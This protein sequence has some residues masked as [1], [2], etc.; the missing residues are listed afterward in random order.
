M[1]VC[2]FFVCFFVFVFLFLFF[3][4]QASQKDEMK[5][6]DDII[7]DYFFFCVHDFILFYRKQS[8]SQYD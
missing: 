4:P 2:F 5:K 1:C 3:W 6:I 8:P 7:S